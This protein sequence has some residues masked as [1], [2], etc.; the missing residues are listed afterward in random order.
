VTPEC[1]RPG[2]L[3]AKLAARAVPA[4]GKGGMNSGEKREGGNVSFVIRLWQERSNGQFW[5]GRI[6]EVDGNN[7][8]AFEDEHGLLN[9]LR[10]RLHSLSGIALSRRR[11]MNDR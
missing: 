3:F 9:F 7:S 6:I 11:R 4:R 2:W 1:R 10:T 8:T 5:R